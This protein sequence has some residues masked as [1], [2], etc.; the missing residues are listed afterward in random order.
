MCYLS[1]KL[2]YLYPFGNSSTR[3]KWR[4]RSSKFAILSNTLLSSTADV[5]AAG[6]QHGPGATGRRH[7]PDRAACGGWSYRILHCCRCLPICAP[8]PLLHIKVGQQGS[9]LW[10]P[11]VWSLWV[12]FA[13][14]SLRCH[15]YRW[16][17][18]G[19]HTKSDCQRENS[20]KA[21][22]SKVSEASP[23]KPAPI[24]FGENDMTICRVSSGGYE[25]NTSRCISSPHVN[26]RTLVTPYRCM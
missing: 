6:P 21:R 9:W 20:S 19:C 11:A 7:H 12:N 2:T 5:L 17:R 8:P 22:D 10:K 23:W 24:S 4:T 16:W 3:H 18:Q 25:S 15:K 14:S 1:A 26:E 13:S